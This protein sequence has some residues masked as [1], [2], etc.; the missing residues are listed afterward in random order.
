MCLWVFTR[1]SDTRDAYAAS[2]EDDVPLSTIQAAANAVIF[3][4]WVFICFVG[5]RI[6]G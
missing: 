2:G 6:K 3:T 5:F 4:W 1:E